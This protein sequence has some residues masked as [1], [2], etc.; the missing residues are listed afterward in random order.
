MPITISKRAQAIKPSPTMTV[1]AMAKKMTAEGYSIVNFGVGEP[2]FNTPEYIKQAAHQAIDDNFTRYTISAGIL[3]LRQAI[4]EKLKR[5][6]DL[7]YTPDEII[8]S[9]GGKAAIITI[10]TAICD[11][12]DEILIPA[13]YWVSYPSQV[14]ML[15][16]KPIYLPTDETTNFKFTPAQ[17]QS[18]LK[19]LSKPK[20]LILNSPNNPSGAVYSKEELLAIGKVCLEH[21]LTVIS[22]EIYEKLVYG[23]AR[24]YSI[25]QVLP[26][27]RD[28][29]I[30]IN[31]VS[32]AYAMTGWRL[33]YAAGPREVIKKASAV[34]EHNAS[35]VTSITQKAAVAALNHDDGS[36]ERMRCEFQKRR[37][38]LVS[39]LQKIPLIKC[40]LPDGAFY[41][42]PNVGRYYHKNK[43][44][45]NDSI[46]LCEYLLKEFHIALV[47]GVA[48]GCDECLRFSYANSMENLIEGIRRFKA[49]LESLG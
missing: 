20:A 45:T 19:S 13:P 34:Q 12:G 17:L 46:R 18:V 47:P 4:A 8:V 2:D 37:D 44:G 6:N 7:E 1:S 49:G 30:L 22:D 9:P 25:A 10:L 43:V 14:E 15:D 32:K 42:F 35:C 39:E 24:H 5:D 27:M 26:P 41:A 33:G 31:G 21:N 36:I 11:P 40:P 28:N 16:G 48:F 3:E 29:T 23:E 38:F